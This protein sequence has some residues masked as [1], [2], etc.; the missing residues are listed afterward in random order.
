VASGAS[1]DALHA[2]IGARLEDAPF[3]ETVHKL[4]YEIGE[5][6]RRPVPAAHDA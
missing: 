5:W 4:F 3:N 2:M 1:G 6:A